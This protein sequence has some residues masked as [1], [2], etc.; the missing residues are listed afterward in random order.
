VAE[1]EARREKGLISYVELT[2]VRFL[3]DNLE[4]RV[5]DVEGELRKLTDLG[6]QAP[7][8]AMEAA[9]KTLE[10]ASVNAD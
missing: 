1:A 7:R 2:D 9:L 5:I 8:V 6:L 3:I 10:S 4:R